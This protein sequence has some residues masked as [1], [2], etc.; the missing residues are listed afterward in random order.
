MLTNASL[1]ERVG[2]EA[3]LSVYVHKRLFAEAT[4]S[5]AEKRTLSGYEQPAKLKSKHLKITKEFW[6]THNAK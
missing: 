5:S 6:I 2:K 1:P 3:K 4:S